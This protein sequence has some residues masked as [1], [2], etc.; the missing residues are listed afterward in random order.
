M[1]DLQSLE[2]DDWKE[3]SVPIG[4]RRQI[5]K[6]LENLKVKEIPTKVDKSPLD[7]VRVA[8]S[9]QKPDLPVAKS[10][11]I[12]E[13]TISSR[14]QIVVNKNEKVTEPEKVEDPEEDLTFEE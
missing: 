11:E 7:K 3:M 5:K 1:E 4:Y 6:S 14:Q 8:F 10:N 2:P 13:N 9:V 12:G